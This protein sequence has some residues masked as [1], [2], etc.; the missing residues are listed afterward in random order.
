MIKPI[1]SPLSARK[2]STYQIIISDD[3]IE[4]SAERV[5]IREDLIA[6]IGDEIVAYVKGPIIGVVKV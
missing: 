6:Y 4:I 5:V 3:V 1:T 2:H